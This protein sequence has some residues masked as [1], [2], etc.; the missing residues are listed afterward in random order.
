MKASNR[1]ILNTGVQY[2]RSFITIVIT[3][4]TSRVV[5]LNLGVNDF[6]IYSLVGGVISMLSFI[7]NNLSTT[8]VRFL[9][10]YRGKGDEK[11]IIEIFNNSV[12]TQFIIGGSLCVILFALTSPII[13]HF[14]NIAPERLSE[15]RVVYYFM[16][17]SLFFNFLSV[18]YLSNLISHENITYSS[19][20]Q[21]LDSL[22]KVPIA[23]SLIWISENK[24]EWYSFWSMLV[25]V[26]NYG[27]YLGYCL[28]KY[29]ECRHLRFDR[30]NFQLFKEMFS[31]MGW[32]I[33]STMCIVA[34]QQ[35]IAILFNR[36]YTTA[37][38]AAYGIAFQV[39]GQLSF[40]ST[41]LTQAINPQIIK[42]EGKGNR[43]KMF[44][45]S[46]I[47]C[48]FSFLLMSMISIPT[49]IYMP[50]ILEVWL[51]E[52]PQ[53][54]TL[55]CRFILLAIQIDLL[56]LNLNTSNQAIGNVKIYSLCLNSIKVLTLPVAWL[57]LHFGY[58]VFGVMVIYVIF[59]SICTISRVIFLHINVNLSITNFLK[60]VGSKIILP[61]SLNLVSCLFLSNVFTGWGM[62][63]TYIFS[64]SITS[65]TVYLTGLTNDEK[66]ILSNIFT[67]LK[68]K[69]TRI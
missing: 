68:L 61:F 26:L 24:L 31:F 32:S 10:Y 67:K 41:S 44:R 28:R 57:A 1:V 22:L 13:N 16:L 12:I 27:L 53:Y 45:L 23:V 60:N 14:L 43:Q 15:A 9:S 29:K 63:I 8:N 58:S 56:T 30:F 54:T 55:F 7:R 21:I 48:K 64:I 20:V 2:I 38:N 4:Y 62:I 5:L 39:S 36:F 46:E 33:Y 47:S 35:G 40:V 59:E 34:R 11:K 65:I 25:I 50:A 37:I 18:P 52:V 19:I 6:G 69:K 42:A 51:K 49:F 17:C 66:E 3:L